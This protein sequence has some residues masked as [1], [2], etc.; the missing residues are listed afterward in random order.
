MKHM[1][2]AWASYF[3]GKEAWVCRF[4]EFGEFGRLRSSVCVCSWTFMSAISSCRMKEVIII[5]MKINA[6]AIV[7]FKNDMIMKIHERDIKTAS[8]TR[9]HFMWAIYSRLVD[10]DKYRTSAWTRR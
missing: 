9:R 6:I 5:C 10:V 2:T 7:L 1:N 4:G 8:I 3:I